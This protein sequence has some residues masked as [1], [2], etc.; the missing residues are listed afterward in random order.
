ME[1]ITGIG[2]ILKILH[3]VGD[4]KFGGG[5]VIISQIV[6]SQLDRGHEVK[7]L[8][9]DAD[10]IKHLNALNVETVHL[11]CIYR[12][13]NLITDCFGIYKLYKFL[14]N[15]HFDVVHTHTTKAGF[16]GRVSAFLA[17]VRRI[18]HTVH[19][20]PFSESSNKFKVYVF[21][22]LERLL[23]L[24][25]S[26]VIFV[27]NYH[28]EWAR[29]LKIVD[30]DKALAIRNGGPMPIITSNLPLQPLNLC[31]DLK[32]IVYVGRLVKEKGLFDLLKAFKTLAEEMGDVHLIF[33]GDGPDANELKELASSCKQ[34]HFTGFVNNAAD[35]L[36]FAD[37]FV[38]PSYREGLSVSAIEAQ[39]FGV[40]SILSDIG[41]NVEISEN[42][43]NALLFK[44]GCVQSLYESLHKLLSDESLRKLYSSKAEVNFIENFSSEKMLDGYKNLYEKG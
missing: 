5:S 2:V 18:Y 24:I 33:V 26:R 15:N 43:N 20:F 27:S 36:S 16:V 12:S 28:L 14:K 13:Y 25:S 29:T 22:S 37:I 38:L 44:V 31:E 30:D 32:K 19:G 9:T 40:P 3:V 11:H 39:A 6:C 8:T 42:G 41:G 23:Y 7:V 35:Y 10:F 4:S 21:S 1:K 34:I 17:N